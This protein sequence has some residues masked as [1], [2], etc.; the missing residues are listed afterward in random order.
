MTMACTERTAVDG[1][2]KIIPELLNRADDDQLSIHWTSQL[3][4]EIW[5]GLISRIATANPMP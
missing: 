5:L 4:W 1:P 3:P 2:A